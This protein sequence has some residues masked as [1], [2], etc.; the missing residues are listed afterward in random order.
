VAPSVDEPFGQV[1]LEAMASG[2]P[3]VTTATGGPLSFVNTERDRPNGWLV[4]P[5]DEGALA[6]ALVE[7]VADDQQRLM[8][9]RNAYEQVRGHFSW[10]ALAHRFTDC[11]E[12]ALSATGGAGA[13]GAP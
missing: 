2:L 1:F 11:Y 13:K 8:K 9:G 4:E 3:V 7:L 10:R 5:D 12:N 6:E